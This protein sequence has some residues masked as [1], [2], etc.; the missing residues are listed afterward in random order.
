MNEED[1]SRLGEFEGR[2]IMALPFLS[3]SRI[4]HKASWLTDLPACSRVMGVDFNAL[5]SAPPGQGQW[6][7]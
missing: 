4:N 3:V 2:V 7:P 6:R 1:R 5:L